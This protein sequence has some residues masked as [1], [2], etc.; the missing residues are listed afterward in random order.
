MTNKWLNADLAQLKEIE[1]D[2]QDLIG[3][4]E[5]SDV[6]VWRT[7]FVDSELKKIWDLATTFRSEVRTFKTK[8]KDTLTEKDSLDLDGQV[9]KLLG[10]VKKHAFAITNKDQEVNP[11]KSMSE[12]EKESLAVQKRSAELQER[13]L[14]EHQQATK[15]QRDLQAA[16]AN[17]KKA[18]EMAKT[19][20]CY[21]KVLNGTSHLALD[22]QPSRDM[23]AGKL[24]RIMLSEKL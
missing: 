10:D 22:I 12:F 17:V 3:D 1:Q 23:M 18:E 13:S 11:I 6:N 7:K 16:A 24:W 9:A 15:E 19:K 14:N 21:E 20:S 5:V 4:L 2:V 8:Y